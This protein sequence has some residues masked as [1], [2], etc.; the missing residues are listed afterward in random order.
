MWYQSVLF[1]TCQDHP[2]KFW[3]TGNPFQ[4][5]NASPACSQ[6]TDIDCFLETSDVICRGCIYGYSVLPRRVPF[7]I[8]AVL[9]LLCA[10][11]QLRSLEALRG[12]FVARE[13]RL[14]GTLAGKMRGVNGGEQVFDTWM[15]RESDLV[16]ATALAYAE[17]EVLDACMRQIQQVCSLPAWRK[18]MCMSCCFWHLLAS[19]VCNCPIGMHQHALVTGA[20]ALADVQCR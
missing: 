3:F 16:Q 9:A 17:R 10:G 4:A 6:I 13:G 15:K 14:L 5:G 8:N 11:G 12:V 20:S 19:D 1:N 7:V 2:A 18:S